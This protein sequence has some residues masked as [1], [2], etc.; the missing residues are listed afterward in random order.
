MQIWS[1]LLNLITCSLVSTV[2]IKAVSSTAFTEWFYAR[3]G[4]IFPLKII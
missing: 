1:I 2:A 3:L 4:G